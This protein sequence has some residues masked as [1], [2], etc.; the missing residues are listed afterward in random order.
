[1]RGEKTMKRIMK[2]TVCFLLVTTI[3]G[4]GLFA[5]EYVMAKGKNETDNFNGNYIVEC[6]NKFMY[7]E[8]DEEYGTD[9][10]E[11]SELLEENNIAQVEL[12]DFEAEKLKNRGVLAEKDISVCGSVEKNYAVKLKRLRKANKLKK[13][14]KKQDT[15]DYNWNIES[16]G[17]DAVS[18]ETE[19]RQDNVKI[20]I[21]DSGIDY[22][23]NINVVNRKNF[24]D[25]DIS[26]LYEDNTGHGTAIAGIIASD[27]KE[28]T[29]KGINPN[30]DI[31][32]AR[33][34]DENNQAPISRVVESIYWAIEEDVDIINISFGTSVNSE[35][36]HNA[37]K[38]AEDAG[39]LI[40]AASGNQGEAGSDNV[41]YPAAFEEVVAVGASTPQGELSDMTSRG[42]E[43][44][45][46]APG[47]N[48]HSVGW[49]GSEV[50]CGGTSIS[51]AH[52][53]GAC[54]LI[55]QKDMSKS[56]EF[57][58][59]LLEVSAKDIA[60][61]NNEY[62]YIDLEYADKIYDE[63]NTQ[64]EQ[65]M[66]LK[67]LDEK[68]DNNEEVAAYDESVTGSWT[69]NGHEALVKEGLGYTAIMKKAV[70]WADGEKNLK[71][72]K[73]NPWFHGYFMEERLSGT[74][75]DNYNY[76]TACELLSE[77]AFYRGDSTKIST[78]KNYEAFG[79][80]L[81]SY[82]SIKNRFSYEKGICGNDGKFIPWEKIL[83][84]Y[85][86]NDYN[87]K[88]FIYGLALHSATDVLA[89][90]TCD[91]NGE[92]IK[93]PYA[94]YT[95]HYS[96]R[97][98]DAFDLA[99]YI[100]NYCVKNNYTVCADAFMSPGYM[101]SGRKYKLFNIAVYAAKNYDD[102]EHIGDYNKQFSNINKPFTYK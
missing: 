2:S 10:I 75:V 64:Y 44:E 91:K 30:V 13:Y 19:D 53:V 100:M 35:I 12:T 84:G 29:I 27:G 56:P 73:D 20:A 99:Q 90:S 24:L 8:I 14:K 28:G 9:K 54:S 49:L 95:Y 15:T 76:I 87:K 70:V 23:E 50:V 51:V 25:D 1:M 34:L 37:I 47:E 7:K 78:Y 40:F 33:I 72:M 32:S 31:Y 86:V 96:N 92:R 5:N 3:A 18:E 65:N 17:I 21:L 11:Q 77:L 16:L 82:C 60:D 26:P 81:Y 80:S 89:H 68:Y 98:K 45:L 61:G 101:T 69:G 63:Y 43:L 97:Y 66:D 59:G 71:G 74:G 46:V 6:K 41:E 83:S 39:I 52:A 58:R 79:L 85:A 36:L 38:D 94:D 62:N 55:W 42:E 4:N 22:C 93:H 88:Y 67:E 48:I 57:V 102:Y